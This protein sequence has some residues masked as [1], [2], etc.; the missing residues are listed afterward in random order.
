MVHSQGPG[1]RRTLL[2]RLLPAATGL[3]LT[4]VAVHLAGPV[5]AP[6]AGFPHPTP[7]VEAVDEPLGVPVPAAEDG[8]TYAFVAVQP[9]SAEPVAY[10][11]CRPIHYV[12]RPDNAPPGAAGM[13]HDAFAR[14]TGVTGLRFVYDGETDERPSSDR[15]PFQPERYGDRWAPVLVTWETERE[16]PEFLTGVVGLGGSA[17]MSLP[18]EPHV[19]VTGTVALDAAAFREILALP[20]G[21]A[22]ARAV[23]LHELGHLVG[24][25]HVTD[26]TQLMFPEAGRLLD[27]ASGDLAGLAQL[28]RG[29][30]VPGL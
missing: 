24:L 26:E 17:P 23:I 28:G 8:G 6:R 9:D 22:D 2:L 20:D 5:A 19:Y 3:A 25:D 13:L 14:V 15:V 7:G 16:N 1:G 27:Y 21:R 30:C 10:D 11:P 4:V 12:M 29:A 18:G